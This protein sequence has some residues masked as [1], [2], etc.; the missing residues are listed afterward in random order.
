MNLQTHWKDDSCY[1]AESTNKWC[2]VRVG[3]KSIVWLKFL[4]D[5][6]ELVECKC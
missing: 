4:K 6:V 1:D 3:W 5:V 2:T